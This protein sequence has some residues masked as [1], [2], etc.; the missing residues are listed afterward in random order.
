MKVQIIFS[1][2]RSMII[3]GVTNY[4]DHGDYWK[5]EHGQEQTS[6]IEGEIIYIGR[7]EVV[8]AAIFETV[9]IPQKR[10]KWL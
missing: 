7:P 2:G 9:P 4:T 1:N 8:P 10:F 3:D 6:Y 5:I